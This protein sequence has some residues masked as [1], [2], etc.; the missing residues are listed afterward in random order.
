MVSSPGLV[1]LADL[2]PTV[3]L[4]P[5]SSE[6]RGTNVRDALRGLV[7]FCRHCTPPAVLSPRVWLS[8][9]ATSLHSAMCLHST[10][11]LGLC[12]LPL[13]PPLMTSRDLKEQTMSSCTA[14]TCFRGRALL[15]SPDLLPAKDNGGSLQALSELQQLRLVTRL[16]P[17][18]RPLKLEAACLL[19]IASNDAPGRNLLRL[20]LQP[21][22][23]SAATTAVLLEPLHVT[24][25]PIAAVEVQAPSL[26]CRLHICGPSTS[27]LCA[28][29][30]VEHK[31]KRVCCGHC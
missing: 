20:G 23:D 12:H 15:C 30:R 22:D 11:S 3:R 28:C 13:L 5:G 27:S 31:V 10:T 26:C 21:Q 8:E 6:Q 7:P 16:V 1:P 9:T 2:Q 29:T 24:D 17:A 18:C 19:V 14:S 25:V 4:I